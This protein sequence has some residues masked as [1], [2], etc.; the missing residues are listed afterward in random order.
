MCCS[1][2]RVQ[3]EKKLWDPG[4]NQ[5]NPS[6]KAVKEN[7]V[8]TPMQQAW[9]ETAQLGRET[10]ENLNLEISK[11]KNS[12]GCLNNGEFWGKNQPTLA[13]RS[14]GKKKNAIQKH[15]EKLKVI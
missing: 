3:T 14:R 11:K 8:M 6:E 7:S 9:G 10:I 5:W 4:D 13:N 12:A 15:Q 2:I 1:K